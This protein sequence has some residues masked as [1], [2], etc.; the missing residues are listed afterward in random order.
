MLG[1]GGF[2]FRD[3]SLDLGM[4]A[5]SKKFSLFSGQSPIGIEGHFAEPRIDPISGQLLAR[6]GTG[7]G[8]AAA[9]SPLAGI[10]AFVDIGDAKAADCGPVL[11]GA[12]AVA[13]R[14][15]KGKP[16]DDVGTGR[17]EKG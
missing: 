16:R 4:R 3:E 7:L 2:S 12:R 13:Q 6:I 17:K 5:D 1:R 8:L 15:S 11:S 14:T 9:A 10:I